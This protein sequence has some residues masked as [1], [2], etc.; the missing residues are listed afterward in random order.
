MSG[1]GDGD[2]DGGDGGGWGET[3]DGA[4]ACG[5]AARLGRAQSRVLGCALARSR[6]SA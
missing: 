2:G 5:G 4:Y 6:D 3:Q 1:W